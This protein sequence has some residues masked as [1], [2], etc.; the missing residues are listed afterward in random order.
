[1]SMYF[2]PDCQRHKDNDY[3][4][5]S[6]RGL[7]EECEFHREE[8][9]REYIAAEIEKHIARTEARRMAH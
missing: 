9:L 5:M 6:E 3:S 2:C 7:C 8:A 4:P 1:M